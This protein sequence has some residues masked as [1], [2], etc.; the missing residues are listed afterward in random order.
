[1]TDNKKKSLYES[2]M[3]DV[4]KT[5]KHHLNRDN[6]INE[7]SKARL[8]WQILYG[9]TN[10]DSQILDVI[11]T[12]NELDT[13]CAAVVAYDQMKR[14]RPVACVV[15]QGNGVSFNNYDYMYCDCM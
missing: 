11:C 1:M 15:K 4:A 2:I 10:Q 12:E 8:H 14:R 6:A 3:K 5:V 9:R 7:A 13:I